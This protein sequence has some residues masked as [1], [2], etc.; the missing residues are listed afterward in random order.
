VTRAK[1]PGKPR[2]RS[3]IA[4]ALRFFKPKIVKARKGGKAY[5]RKPKHPPAT[6]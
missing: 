6:E 1:R 3:G 4:A 2:K 5:R